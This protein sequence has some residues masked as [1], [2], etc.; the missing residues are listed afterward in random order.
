MLL[1]LRKMKRGYFANKEFRNYLLY[2]LGEMVLVVIG[3]LIALQIDNWNDEKIE[4]ETLDSY[5]RTIAGNIGGDLVAVG[6]IRS[7][8]ENAYELSLRWTN[9]DSRKD[10]LSTDEVTFASRVLSQA[11]QAHTFDVNSSGF[12]AL[13]SSGNLDQ[14][15]GRNVETLPYDYY[16]TAARI[17][18]SERGHD[19]YSR[20]LWLQ[21]LAK[22]PDDLERWE[23]ANPQVLTDDRF[24]TLQPI[25]RQIL[26]G[27]STKELSGNPQSVGALI[28]DYDRLQRLGEAFM[29]MV[30]TGI[31]DFDDAAG[32]VLGG[33]YD[34]AGG[35]GYP[36]VIADGQVSWQSYFLLSSDSNDHRVSSQPSGDA[37]QSPFHFRS[38]QRTGDSLH[39]DYTGGAEWA[40]IWFGIGT[41]NSNQLI[42][43]YS[44]FDKLLL[45]M[46]GDVGGEKIHLN[47]ED[48]DDL[49]SG[50]STKVVLQ[51]TDQWQPYEID[52]AEFKTADLKI[53]A[54]PLGF[55]FY[56]DAQSF[57]V[58]TAKYVRTD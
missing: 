41:D 35:I 31:M 3:I 56:Q 1:M 5:L 24:Q 52:L 6:A 36:S 11:S 48:R 10:T 2:A 15:Q 58:R 40:D 22:W 25:Y 46:K 50:T 4:Q 47:I 55:V 38:F 44:T 21:I 39:I 30:E 14:M 16:D 12:E 23:M 17:A 45:E 33:I 28:L 53:L 51:L 57:S 49:A 34:P 29:W 43:D 26:R 18:N 9:F 54:R 20:L 19:E 13:K 8:R 27:R 42:T 7:E 37:L 32:S